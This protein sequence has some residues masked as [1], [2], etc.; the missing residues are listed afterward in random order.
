MGVRYVRELGDTSFQ[1]EAIPPTTATYQLLHQGPGDRGF[2]GVARHGGP[3]KKLKPDRFEDVS[4]WCA[5]DGPEDSYP[6]HRRRGSRQRV[7]YRPELGP[8]S[9]RPTGS[10]LPEQVMRSRRA[11]GYSL[12]G[13][14]AAPRHGQEEAE[15]W[16]S[17]EPSSGKARRDGL[18]TRGGRDLRPEESSRYGFTVACRRLC[19][20]AYQTPDEV[21]HL[22]ALMAANLSAVMS[23][24]T[25]CR[26]STT[27]RG[28][29]LASAAGHQRSSY[30]RAPGRQ[31]IVW[32]GRRKGPGG[33]DR[34]H[35]RGARA[36]AF[37]DLAKFWG[38]R[39]APGEPPPMEPW[40]APGRSMRSRPTPRAPRLARNASGGR[41]GREVRLAGE[42]LRR[43]DGEAQPFDRCARR[44]GRGRAPGN[45]QQ[46]LGFYHMAIRSRLPRR[47][48]PLRAHAVEASYR[49]RAVMLDGGI[50]RAVSIR[51]PRTWRASPSTA[52]GAWSGGGRRALHERFVIQKTRWWWCAARW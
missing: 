5:T 41:Q 37:R 31:S 8:Y 34:E 47:A 32:A 4:P 21:H 19:V 44:C 36:P 2:S 38:A 18:P 50:K 27:T 13:R 40:C 11:G 10:C 48:A 33:S 1:L 3:L 51:A 20:L 22:A 29:R 45:E 52:S 7:G 23:I 46:S 42:P 17:S 28:A 26:C 14:P 16:H 9:A 24:P 12:A 49:L 30:V 15:G 35:R 6:I 39:P 25:R 43:S